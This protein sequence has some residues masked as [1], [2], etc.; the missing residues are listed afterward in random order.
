MTPVTR[1]IYMSRIN[2]SSGRTNVYNLAKTT[3]ALNSQENF[4]AKVVT[5]DH[6][7]NTDSFFERM[8]VRKHFPIVCLGVTNT[9]SR[10]RGNK[11]YELLTLFVANISLAWY[12]LWHRKEFDVIYF[13]DEF[14]APLVLWAKVL[15]KKSFFEIHSVLQSKHHQRLNMLGIRFS[16]G[17]IAISGGV[18]RYYEPVNP[19]VII[20]LCSAAEDAW[21]DHTTSQIEFRKKLGIPLEGYVLGYAGVVGANPN[22]DYYE[23]D[24]VIKSLAF[25]PQKVKFV[26]VGEI[27]SNA[28]W[29]RDLAKEKGV[30]DRVIIFPWQE[31]KVTSDFLLSFDVIIIPKRKKDL[32]GDS[33]AKMFPALAA[34]RPIVAGNAESIIEVLTDNHDSLIVETNT[35][36]GWAKAILRIYNDKNLSEKLWRQAEIT[37]TKYT[38]EKRGEAIGKFIEKIIGG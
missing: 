10:F 16:D 4:E 31:R 35:H 18:K 25:L 1:M 23:L 27:N 24:D 8:G 3:E 7:K 32:I 38:W 36:E 30:E 21:Y 14:L 26:I 34:R 29:L 2:L 20:S 28:D 5:T 22:N 9:E 15:R 6:A 33:P 17:V 13:R 37:K 12:L 11:L 19:N